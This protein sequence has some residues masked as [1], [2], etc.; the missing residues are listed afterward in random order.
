MAMPFGLEAWPLRWLGMSIEV[1]LSVGRFVSGLPGAVST[2]PAWP[3]SVIVLLS[4]GGLWLGLWRR[5]W[6]WFGLLPIAAALLWAYFIRGPDLLVARD[7][8]TVA[9]RGS[10]GVLRLV[11]QAHDSYSAD[12][13]LK[14]DGDDRVADNAVARVA[15]GV[16]CDAFG[17]IA[18]RS[19]GGLIAITQ[20]IDGLP[21]DC[22]AAQIVVSAMPTRQHCLGP[23]LVIDKFDVARNGGY[24]VWFDTP[25]RVE[26]VAGERGARPW[27]PQYRRI[28]PTNRPW[29]R[30][31][32]AP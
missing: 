30:T 23:K 31:R 5:N 21:E 9:I 28:S 20:R 1:M 16:R 29:T 2:V 32:S 10:D 18:R 24:A 4:F 13:W 12:Q 11:R 8:L 19:D 22:A 15:D 14:R 27:A 6:R 3:V 7:G 26:T 25:L 17:C